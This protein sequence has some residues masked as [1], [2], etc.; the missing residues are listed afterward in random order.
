MTTYTRLIEKG[1]LEGEQIGIQK[2]EQIGIQK[3]KLEVVISLYDDGFETPR[4]AKIV[5]L[6]EEEV[7]NILEKNGRLK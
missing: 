3:G 7:V 6:Q 1:K 2:G 5:K 4:I